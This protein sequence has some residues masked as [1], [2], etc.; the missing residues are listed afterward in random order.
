MKIYSLQLHQKNG[1]DKLS[2]KS[3]SD[4]F[5][6]GCIDF[7]ILS[8]Y[9]STDFI[10]TICSKIPKAFRKTVSLKFVF[11]GFGGRKL[12]SQE[13]ELTTLRSYLKN[14]GFSK[15]DIYLNKD[16]QIFHSKLYYIK[17]P[18]SCN[19]F[20]GSAN[21][22]EA[23]F[24]ENEEILINTTEN[25][26]KA[27]NYINFVIGT[28][29]PLDKISNQTNETSLAGLIKSGSIF[30]KPTNRLSFSFEGLKIPK[31]DEEKITA[32]LAKP[33]HSN[34]GK[35]WGAYNL[36]TAIGLSVDDGDKP[37]RLSMK[38]LAIETCY[39]YWSPEHYHD[40]IDYLIAEKTRGIREDLE[41][42]RE[43]L[44]SLGDDKVLKE[45]N[46]YIQDTKNIYK[47]IKSPFPFSRD[48]C[49][50]SIDQFKRFVERTKEKLNN[51]AIIT[52][53]STPL[54]SS[55]MPEIWQDPLSKKEFL[56]SFFDS[57]AFILENNEI[58]NP[59]IKTFQ[60]KIGLE[61]YDSPEKIA[62]K[63]TSFFATNTYWRSD[64]W[65]KI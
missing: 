28:S 5:E 7:F 31:S 54:V 14:Q 37:I 22:S 27:L 21:A 16:Y 57:I 41:K 64:F 11:N 51:S 35:A 20:I 52:K 9:Y 30:F 29:I 25:T 48:Q 10:E 19:L 3:I 55:N 4:H 61:P 39:G 33:R 6:H 58:H 24:K 49:N 13:V 8:A 42:T 1:F 44:N 23:A 56:D 62:Q 36:K 65:N 26:E 59:I 32:I 47:Q 45:Y 18:S 46:K 50:S 15:I 17:S 60:G 43:L 2:I 38:R 63:F 53:M 12:R 40:H 34:P